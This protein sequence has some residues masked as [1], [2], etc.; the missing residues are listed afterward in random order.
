MGSTRGQNPCGLEAVRNP[1]SS[2]HPRSARNP[3]NAA[4]CSDPAILILT[5]LASFSV[6]GSRL[7]LRWVGEGGGG[8]DN[9]KTGP[10]DGGSIV[11]CQTF[12]KN[13]P[14]NVPRKFNKRM[15]FWQKICRAW[16]RNVRKAIICQES[17]SL[18]IFFFQRQHLSTKT[19]IKQIADADKH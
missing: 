9:T 6:K 8:V 14:R 10:M 16:R 11:S 4:G 19:H 3:A 5:L 13:V 1:N 17:D 7:L 2:Q 15:N 18:T 12:I